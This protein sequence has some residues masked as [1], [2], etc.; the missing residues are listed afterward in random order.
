MVEQNDSASGVPKRP[1]YWYN[2]TPTTGGKVS[3]NS[4]RVLVK[5]ERQEMLKAPR[6]RRGC[7]C[8]LFRPNPQSSVPQGLNGQQAADREFYFSAPTRQH[9]IPFCLASCDIA[10]LFANFINLQRRSQRRHSRLGGVHWPKNR[11]DGTDWADSS[12]RLTQESHGIP[13]FEAAAMS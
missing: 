7:V 2:R 9:R 4:E 11:I 10:R 6:S 3:S 12:S 5:I 1:G 8:V 13:G